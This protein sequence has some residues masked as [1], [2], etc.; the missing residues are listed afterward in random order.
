M[1]ALVVV[2][3][4][5]AAAQTIAQQQ[6]AI[7]QVQANK[8]AI[9]ALQSQAGLQVT[10]VDQQVTDAA[11][12]KAV[13]RVLVER[14][15]TDPL[16]VTTGQAGAQHQVT[17][18]AEHGEVSGRARFYVPMNDKS[19]WIVTFTAPLTGKN[20]T[21]ATETGLGNNASANVGM[22]LTFWSFVDKPQAPRNHPPRHR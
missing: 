22:K 15:V 3:A 6:Q 17:M 13:R 19:D 11:L 16:S 4:V 18:V 7:E 1:T 10:A 5:P 9:Q 12:A 20:A 14:T 8:G 21:F 2:S